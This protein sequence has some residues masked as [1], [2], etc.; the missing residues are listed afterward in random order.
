MKKSILMLA[1][2]ALLLATPSCKKGEN[3]PALSLSSRKARISGEWNVASYES[4]SSTVDGNDSWHNTQSFDGT[5]ITGTWSQ[6]VSGTTTS[7]N[8]A[9]VTTV[10]LFDFIINKDGTYS[11]NRNWVTVSSGTDTWT[12]FDYT[13]TET[14]SY[15]ESGS[16]SFI[17][18]AKDEYKN[19]ERV[20]MNATHTVWTS[21]T[22]T[23]TQLGGGITNTAIG[24]TNVNDDT[25]EIGENASI[26]DIDMLKG[27]EMTLMVV[28][29]GVDKF[30]STTSGGTST[31]TQETNEST[32]TIQLTAK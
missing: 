7:G 32:M 20:V 2:G 4:E 12:G 26:F 15:T 27:K 8:D 9:D 24:N 29:G 21:Q 28:S 23:V 22:T 13:D 19:K 10:S 11:M 25:Y 3:D 5:K 31:T 14:A 1:A 30:T 6:T 17:G 18:K 16:W